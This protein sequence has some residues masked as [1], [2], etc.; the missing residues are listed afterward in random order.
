M[1]QSIFRTKPIDVINAKE[2]KEEL[3]RELG[4]WDLIAIGVGGTVGSGVFATTGDII[5]GAAGPAAFLSWMIA[6]VSCILSGFAYME[7]SSL[8]PSSGSTLPTLTKNR[9]HAPIR[10]ANRSEENAI[11]Y[12]FAGGFDYVGYS[13]A[14][15]IVHIGETGTMPIV[16]FI[17]FLAQP[18]LL[19]TPTATFSGEPCCPALRLRWSHSVP[20]ATLWNMVSFGILVSF[21]MTNSALIVVRTRESSPQKSYSLTGTIVALSCA[22]MFV[23][24]KSYVDRD[25]AAGLVISMVF[26]AATFG[27]AAV[28]FF[29][30]PQNQGEPNMFRAPL[31]PFVPM[32]AIVVNWYLIAQLNE[33]D[34]ARGCIWIAAAIVSYFLYGFRNSAGRTGW[35]KTLNH[36]VLC[37][38]EV[39][40]SMNYMVGTGDLKANPL[41]SPSK[42]L[43]N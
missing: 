9:R 32:L 10:R 33:K 21:I 23:F 31:V 1:F 27:V 26:L 19:W 35:V 30:C 8:V 18:R 12:S 28:I 11:P 36:D 39:R 38:N 5:S 37:L 20:F 29:T 13:A 4:L 3:R 14:K 43:L 42:A 34:I 24:Q 6:G 17:A 41:H 40:P 7:M 2:Q 15:L 16:V 22:A 25:S